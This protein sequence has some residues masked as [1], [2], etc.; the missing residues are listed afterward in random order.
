MEKPYYMDEN[1]NKE[2]YDST[3][4]INGQEIIIPPMTKE[5][6]DAFME[7]LYSFTQVYKTG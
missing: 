7:Q 6:T 3:Y 2:E 5:E 1:G 4:Y